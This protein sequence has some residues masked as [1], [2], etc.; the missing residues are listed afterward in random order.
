MRFRGTCGNCGREFTP[1]L[2]V[3]GGGHC[4]WCGNAFSRDYTALIA[5]ALQ[6]AE[7]AGDALEDAL[8]ELASMNPDMQLDE[9][10]ILEPLRKHLRTIRK[11]RRARV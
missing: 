6:R 11:G 7:A 2:V 8:E 4:P 5:N 9:E 10:A 1:E 3:Q